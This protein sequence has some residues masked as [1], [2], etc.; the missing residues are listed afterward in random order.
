[1]VS[2]IN[3]NVVSGQKDIVN[4]FIVYRIKG[5]D[6]NTYQVRN[7]LFA[8][9]NGSSDKFV[10]F[11]PNGDL[12]VSGTTNDY[13]IKGSNPTPNKQPIAPY[14]AKANAGEINKWVCLSIHWDNYTSP[15]AGASK[16][17]VMDKS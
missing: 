8:H 12:V 9:D 10:S 16:D 6:T 13:I 15:T 2:D 14:K 17:I 4:I 7:G 11:S 3:L 1:M 5:Y